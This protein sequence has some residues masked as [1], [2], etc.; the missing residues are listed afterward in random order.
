MRLVAWNC[1]EKFDDNYRRLQALEFDIAVVSECSPMAAGHTQERDLSSVVHRPVGA[2]NG[3]KHLGVFAQ[4]PWSLVPLDIGADYP[5]CLVAQVAGPI[6][7]TLVGIWAQGP[8]YLPDRPSY[9][10]QAAIVSTRSFPTWSVTWS[11]RVT[12]TRQA[13]TQRRSSDTKRM[14]TPLRV[15]AS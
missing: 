10:K 6:E 13:T 15:S 7:F 8:E 4:A 1:C 9:A 5:W 12:S 2:S 11:L 3:G 14:W